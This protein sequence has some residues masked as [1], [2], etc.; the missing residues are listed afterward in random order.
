MSNKLIKNSLYLSSRSADVEIENFWRIYI[1]LNSNRYSLLNQ[2]QAESVYKRIK[3]TL[4][5][6]NKDYSNLRNI[7][8]KISTLPLPFV[9]NYTDTKKKANRFFRKEL[10]KLFP[11]ELLLLIGVAELY[12]CYHQCHYPSRNVFDLNLKDHNRNLCREKKLCQT[13]HW[14]CE[15]GWHFPFWHKPTLNLISWPH[16]KVHTKNVLPDHCGANEDGYYDIDIKLSYF[17]K[18]YIEVQLNPDLFRQKKLNPKGLYYHRFNEAEDLEKR[19]FQRIKNHKKYRRRKQSN[20]ES[21]LDK[22]IVVIENSVNELL[23]LKRNSL[24]QKR[25]RVKKKL[26]K[27][28]W[29]K[30]EKRDHLKLQIKALNLLISSRK[31]YWKLTEKE[32]WIWV[33]LQNRKKKYYQ[34][35]KNSTSWKINSY[36]S[37]DKRYVSYDNKIRY[38]KKLILKSSG[39]KA[40][41]LRQK[42]DQ[43]IFGFTEFKKRLRKELKIPE[44]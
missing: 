32:Q 20:S 25:L 40:K 19:N 12:K 21:S 35:L 9:K 33:N 8:H 28:P 26:E 36:L 38:L 17:L 10:K 42:K 4:S 1:Y 41:K 2:K 29:N 27:L 18:N 37:K 5:V 23:K 22:K 15:Q 11:N 34:N 30:T 44:T 13:I 31:N 43:L 24:I 6:M 3:N 39:E 7:F 16:G 14:T